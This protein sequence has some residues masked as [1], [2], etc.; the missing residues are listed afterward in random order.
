MERSWL[1]PYWVT[2]VLAGLCVLLVAVDAALVISNESAQATVN[3]R[4]QILNQA[5]QLARLNDILMRALADVELN[6]KD[7]PLRD[8][9]ARHGLTA[10]PKPAAPATAAPPE[11]L[12]K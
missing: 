10:T 9:L 2:T 8:M 6:T 11:P 12:G 1:S 5:P 3:Q 7:D 4:Q